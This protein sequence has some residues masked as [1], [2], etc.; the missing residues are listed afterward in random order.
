MTVACFCGTVYQALW[1]VPVCP[2]CGTRVEQDQPPTEG[3][4]R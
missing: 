2:S 1:G 4:T 3:A